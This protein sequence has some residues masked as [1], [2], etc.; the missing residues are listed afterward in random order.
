MLKWASQRFLGSRII[1]QVK[2]AMSTFYT[3]VPDG[4]ASMPPRWNA[5]VTGCGSIP[6]E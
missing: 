2:G 1:Q 4:P 3:N 5:S 6:H